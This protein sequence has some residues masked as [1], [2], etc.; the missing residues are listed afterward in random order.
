MTEPARKRA[1]GD[2]HPAVVG[3]RKKLDSIREGTLP[4]LERLNARID[5][6]KAKSDPPRDERREPP[7]VDPRREPEDEVPVDV[8]KLRALP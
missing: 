3:M 2:N 8:V 7:V 6:L 5:K 4:E 1:S